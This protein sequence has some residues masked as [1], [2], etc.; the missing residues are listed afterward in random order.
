MQPASCY[1]SPIPSPLPLLPPSLIKLQVNPPGTGNV[2]DFQLFAADRNLPPSVF[3]S[4]PWDLSCSSCR[5]LHCGDMR[6]VSYLQVSPEDI[7]HTF[8]I[9][10]SHYHAIVCCFSAIPRYRSAQ[11][12]FTEKVLRPSYGS[13]LH[14]ESNLLAL[15]NDK[16]PH[17]LRSCYIPQWPS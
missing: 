12:H 6:T 14:N 15:Q 17:L 11:S 2:P 4:I 8:Q 16:C 10:T 13:S 1:M 3:Q 5:G 7:N 9:F